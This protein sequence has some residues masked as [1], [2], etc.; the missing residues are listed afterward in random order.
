MFVNTLPYIAARTG[1]W[2]YPARAFLTI[3]KTAVAPDSAR[4]PCEEAGPAA[5]T[6]VQLRRVWTGSVQLHS[7]KYVGR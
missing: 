5:S 4:V 1:F 6:A 2:P 7:G 3:E